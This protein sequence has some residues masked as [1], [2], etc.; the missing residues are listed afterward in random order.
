MS[1]ILAAL[2]V[3]SS[4][5]ADALPVISAI[6]TVGGLGMSVM[7][8][9]AQAQ[10]QREAYKAQSQ[11]ARYNQSVAEANAQAVEAAAALEEQR[12]R[13]KAQQLLGSQTAAYGKAGVTLEGTP[14]EVM[15][16]T[17]ADV[18]EDILINRYNYQVQA[19]RQ[20]SQAG[21][22]GYEAGRQE[23]LAQYPVTA[24]LMKGASSLLTTG[25]NWM[26]SVSTRNQK[27]KV[28]VPSYSDF[29]IN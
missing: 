10:Q 3:I 28:P 26:G 5:V 6:A 23:R 15:A 17:A 16:Q 22:Y 25:A 11:A 8:G 20:R 2:P 4:A 14:L 27:Y 1:F 21:F 18:E 7:G 19:A 9:V 12:S 13:K 24:A 29:S